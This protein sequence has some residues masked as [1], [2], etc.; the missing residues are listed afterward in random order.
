MLITWKREVWYDDSRGR[1]RTKMVKQGIVVPDCCEA[2]QTHLAVTLSY[3]WEDLSEEDALYAEAPPGLSAS[4]YWDEEKQ[5]MTTSELE[6]WFNAQPDEKKGKSRFDVAKPIWRAGMSVDFNIFNA[7]H[8]E[9]SIFAR[10]PAKFCPFCGTPLPE[11]ERITKKKELPGRLYTPEADG[12]YC[13][14]CD[15]RS[16]NCTCMYPECGW[17]TVT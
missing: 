2:A 12:D 6:A 5:E 4:S 15:A 10:P 13:G 1:E 9:A 17:R 7:A 14:T 11:I 8:P 16:M 3:R